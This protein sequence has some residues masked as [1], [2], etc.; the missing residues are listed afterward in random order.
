MIN[1]L[2]TYR[3]RRFV[4]YWL[5]VIAWMSLIFVLS[6]ISNVDSVVREGPFAEVPPELK[7]PEFAHAVEFLVLAALVYRLLISYQA[8]AGVYMLGSVLLFT[9]GYGMVD[10]FHQSFVPGRD[11]SLGDVALDALGAT[12]GLAA[13]HTGARLNR[14]RK[15]FQQ[16]RTG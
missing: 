15:S 2:P 6:H 10:E 9:I 3:P 4:F 1:V 11:A 16:R 5:P 7:S 12:L 8:V 14:L 13:A